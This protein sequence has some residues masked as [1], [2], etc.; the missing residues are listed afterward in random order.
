VGTWHGTGLH[1]AKDGEKVL[2]LTR[3]TY[4]ASRASLQFPGCGAQV[5]LTIPDLDP[6]NPSS[7]DAPPQRFGAE[8]NFFTERARTMLIALYKPAGGDGSGRKFWRLDAAS[9]TPFRCLFGSDFPRAEPPN[10]AAECPARPSAL[11]LLRRADGWQGTRQA[12][13]PCHAPTEAEAAASVAALERPFDAAAFLARKQQQQQ[14]EEHQLSSRTERSDGGGGC[15]GGGSWCVETFMDGGFV[16][17]P[18][19]LR[20]GSNKDGALAASVELTFGTLHEFPVDSP[21]LR[22][23]TL[24]YKNHGQDVEWSLEEY[25]PS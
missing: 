16:V 9:V 5:S 24:A 6:T 2:S 19:E 17:L 10:T 14:Q 15:G 20:P 1:F 23:V 4:N 3:S 22:A 12:F 13:G 18:E 25:C 7:K 8:I 21:R 11:E